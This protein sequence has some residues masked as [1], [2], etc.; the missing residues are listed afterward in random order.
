MP[1]IESLLD[2]DLYKL[3]M[4]QAVLHQHPAAEAVYRF[5]CRTPG[6]DLS[7]HIDEI[8]SE[9]DALCTLWFTREE[10]DW[11]R[12][13]RFMKPDFV[14]FLGLFRLDRKYLRLR[15][16]SAEQGGIELEASGPWLHTILF[17][18]PLLAIVSEV[19]MR[20]AAGADVRGEGLRRLKD[21]AG[22]LRDAVGYEDCRITDFGTRRR[23]SRAWHG[24]VVAMLAEEL[25]P[26]FAGTSNVDLARRLGLNPQGTMAH[27]W[28]Q[29][30]QALGPRLR[31][32]Q[33]AAFDSWARE[34]RGDLGIA[35]TDVIGL[36]AFLRDFDLYFC[37]LFDGMRHDSGDPFEWGERMIAHLQAHRIDP[38]GKVLVFSDSLDIDL[39]MRL[40]QRFRGRAR[41]SFG[42]GTNLTN[43]VGVPPLSVV[44]KMVRCNGQPVA[45]LSD[46]PGKTM[47]DDP[48][49][50]AYLRQVFDVA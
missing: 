48:G 6:V 33:V 10:L 15:A 11:L 40:Y 18:V 28:L 27:E 14:D 26:K 45:K 37:K 46:S 17:E 29:A 24:E 2:T 31:D 12:G 22:R 21:K 38:M 47:C 3:T 34:Y 4:M 44:M 41:M 23:Y 30:F 42:I 36:D 16:S 35:L 43:D 19:H 32:S 39:V 20:H 7:R 9:I 13:L 25:G 1:V 5:R 8:S 49:Y 50:L